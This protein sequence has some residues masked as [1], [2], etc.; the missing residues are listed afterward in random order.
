MPVNQCIDSTTFL[1][2][3]GNGQPAGFLDRRQHQPVVVAVAKY[4]H[5]TQ[6]ELPKEFTLLDVLPGPLKPVRNS[7]AFQLLAGCAVRIGGDDSEIDEF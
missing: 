1:V 3:D 7:N 2:I 4:S 5:M 6:V